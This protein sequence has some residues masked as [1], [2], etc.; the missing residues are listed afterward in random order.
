MNVF[1]QRDSVGAVLRAIPY[2]IVDFDVL[3]PAAAR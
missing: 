2:E 1:L 3:G